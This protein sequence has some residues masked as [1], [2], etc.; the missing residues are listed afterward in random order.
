MLEEFI[1]CDN[2]TL[3]FESILKSL[4]TIDENGN[5]ALRV[6]E[7]SDSE[8][9]FYDCDNKEIPFENAIRKSIVLVNG[10]PA[11]NLAV[12]IPS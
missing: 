12:I 5:A 4:I 2:K 10:L 11:L 8:T 1:G 9:P 7:N 6:V 3:S